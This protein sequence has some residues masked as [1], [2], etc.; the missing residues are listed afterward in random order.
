MQSGNVLQKQLIKSRQ[1]L[2]DIEMIAEEKAREMEE[3]ENELKKSE[4]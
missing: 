3:S 1:L 4:V 2:R